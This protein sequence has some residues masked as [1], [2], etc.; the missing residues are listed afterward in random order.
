TKAIDEIEG[1]VA[2]YPLPHQ[3]VV[4]DLV[5]DL[6]NFYAQHA[7]V[8]PWMKTDSPTPPDRERLQSKA[9]RAKL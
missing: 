6:T 9:D 7:S 5:S 4:K 8:E 3:R 2:I 1:D